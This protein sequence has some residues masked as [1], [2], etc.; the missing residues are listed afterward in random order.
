MTEKHHTVSGAFLCALLDFIRC[1]TLAAII[2]VVKHTCV[3]FPRKPMNGHYHP[4]DEE[5]D[6]QE[7]MGL[8][9]KSDYVVPCTD[10]QK[11]KPRKKRCA[12]MKP[13]EVM[14]M[15]TRRRFA[16]KSSTVACQVGAVIACV[17]VLA[18]VWVWS[19]RTVQKNTSILS[20]NTLNLGDIK[21]RCLD[22]SH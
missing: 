21:Y 8:L 22:V 1:D 18:G 15:S 2:V 7:M 9:S 11:K 4:D 19:G 12:D 5:D 20:W 14:H 6:N 10:P 3:S 16:S 13:L 17:S